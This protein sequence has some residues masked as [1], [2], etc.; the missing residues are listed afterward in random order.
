MAEVLGRYSNL[1]A[2]GFT[3]TKLRNLAENHRRTEA[4]KAPEPR[5]Q[6]RTRHILAGKEADVRADYDAGVDC[7]ALAQKYGLPVS[8][9][10]A[11]LHREGI[12]LRSGGKLTPQDVHKVAK[13]RA[14]GWTYQAI[15][16]RYGCSRFTV[17]NT[18]KRFQI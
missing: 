13:L 18:L 4:W 2:T 10:L 17:A 7:V 14:D 8:T 9:M 15:G 1:S 12:E 5:G 16:E 11:W 6:R 3:V